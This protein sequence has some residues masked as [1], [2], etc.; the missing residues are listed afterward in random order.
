MLDVHTH[1]VTGVHLLRIVLLAI[2][3]VNFL[4][5]C[6]VYFYP[7]CSECWKTLPPEHQPPDD[8]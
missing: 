6:D 4:Q 8:R 3:I 7:S 2:V 1:V 5:Q